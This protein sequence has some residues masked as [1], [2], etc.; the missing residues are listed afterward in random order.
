MSLAPHQILTIAIELLLLLVGAWMLARVL[1][2]PESR[3]VVFGRYRI[4]HWSISGHEAVLLALAIVL[5]G[6]IGQGLAIRVF[7]DMV[8]NATDRAGLEVILHGMGFHATALLGWPLFYFFRRRM[9]QDYGTEPPRF[10]REHRLEPRALLKRSFTTL[11]LA[12]PALTLASLGWTALLRALGFSDAPQDLIAIFGKVESPAVLIAM[13]FVACV[14]APLN[15][16]LLF[17]GVIFRFCRQRFGRGIAL[18]VSGMMFG[19]LHG[20]LAGFVPLALLGVALA[21][22]Y[23]QSGDIRVPIITHGFF[24]LNTTLVILA[25]IPGT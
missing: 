20:N 7:G 9:Q 16:E 19:A 4:S 21:I 8:A 24:N 14:V 5:C 1:S 10:T 2:L 6:M 11:L 18:V 3:A 12:L 13:L 17:R 15:E 22:A 25:G 23:E